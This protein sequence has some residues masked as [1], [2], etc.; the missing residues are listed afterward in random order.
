M[1]MTVLKM[2]KESILNAV[3]L[4]DINSSNSIHQWITS[5]QDV[6]RKDNELLYKLIY[7]NNEIYLYIQSKTPFN[8]ENIENYG[9]IYIKS[10]NLIFNCSLISFDL[11]AFPY[12]TKNNKR[13]YIKDYQK[14]IEWLQKYFSKCGLQLLEAIDYK[15]SK[16]ILDKDKIKEIPTSSFKGIAKV[17]DKNIFK[18]A[19]IN[20]FGRFKNYGC[21][22]LLFKE[23]L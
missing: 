15:Q 2:N 6:S 4:L 3:S 8:I 13:Y 17:I 23:V 9:F 19:V 12:V 11:Q 5:K 20:G 10:F 7:Q 22:L 1:Y 14:R 18:Q 16:T 21:G